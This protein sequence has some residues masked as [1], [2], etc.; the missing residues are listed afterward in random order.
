[1]ICGW[2]KSEG[3]KSL[4]IFGLLMI[5]G[6]DNFAG[7]KVFQYFQVVD[8][9]R[10]RHFCRRKSLWII[11]GCWSFAAKRILQVKKSLNISKLLMICGY[12]KSA[13]E[14]IFEYFRG[15][16]DLQ[17]RQICRR[18]SLRMFSGYWWFAAKTILHAEKIFE[19]YQVV[20]DLRLRQFCRWKCLWI[21]SGYRWSAAKTIL[22]AKK[23][24]NVFRLFMI[25]GP[26]N[27]AGEKISEYFQ[28]LMNC[29]PDNFAGEKVFE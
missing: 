3:E 19:F 5:C 29:G 25:C 6:K 14:K 1:M 28:L 23:S 18:K 4:N 26:D 9:L 15:I 12:D 8:D 11:S 2:D 7:E 13:G 27:S 20:D 10:P 17:P 22:Q 16:D 24:L 21:F